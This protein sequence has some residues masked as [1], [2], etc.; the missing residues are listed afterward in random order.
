MKSLVG[1][2]VFLSYFVGEAQVIPPG[3][4]GSG[5]GT[6]N[7][8]L[9]GQTAYYGANGTAVSGIPSPLSFNVATYGAKG[10]TRY[11]A[12]ASINGTTTITCTT[13]AFTSADVGK[14]VWLSNTNELP[15]PQSS[16]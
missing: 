9:L 6:V 10:D 2:L 7:A 14:L 8:G 4:G 15:R 3:G 5:S 1:L 12:T 16:P 11:N 13:C